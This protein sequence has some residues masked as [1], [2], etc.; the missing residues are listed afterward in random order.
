MSLNI[1]QFQ[2]HTHSRASYY[3]LN[4]NDIILWCFFSLSSAMEFHENLH[5]MAVKEGLKGRK[6]HKAVE[7]FTW[8]ITILK[9]TTAACTTPLSFLLFSSLWPFPRFFFFN[10]LSFSFSFSSPPHFQSLL[11][12][13]PPFSELTKATQSRS[14]QRLLCS[15]AP[16]A[17]AIYE[18]PFLNN[19]H[20]Q[21]Q[22][23]AYCFLSWSS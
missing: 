10:S 16:E 13:T 17:G 14:H 23:L 20:Q 18:K 1:T 2:L 11:L 4:E 8:N 21:T 3:Y 7:S 6:L 22:L 9:V 15:T 12:Y 5:D 19:Q